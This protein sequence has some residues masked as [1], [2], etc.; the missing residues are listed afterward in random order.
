MTTLP[1]IT[2]RFLLSGL[3]IALILTAAVILDGPPTLTNKVLAQGDAS[4][5]ARYGYYGSYCSPNPYCTYLPLIVRQ[6]VH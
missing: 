6:L 1:S 4:V 2:R 5:L 3:I